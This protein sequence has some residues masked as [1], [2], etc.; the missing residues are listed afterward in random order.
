MRGWLVTGT[1]TGVGKTVVA[2]ALARWCRE[3]GQRVGVCKPVATGVPE[4]DVGEDTRALLEAAQLSLDWSTR[5]TPFAFP[6]PAAPTV[7]ARRAGRHLDFEAVVAAVRSWQDWVDWLVVEGVGGFLCPL[8]PGKTV[9]DLAV[10]L[11][12][13]LLIVARTSL[14]TLNHT[15]L[16]VEAAE[17]RNLAIA[18]IVLNEATKPT[19]SW[20]ERTCQE[21]LRRWLKIPILGPIPFCPEPGREA[22]R[23]FQQLSRETL[24]AEITAS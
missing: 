8:T 14:G 17:R 9:A 6:E 20:A 5:V 19:G 16:T 4:G 21:E 15:L 10:E 22:L 1:D 13:P 2:S 24:V 12:F 3:S 11:R 18:G 7:A 23:I